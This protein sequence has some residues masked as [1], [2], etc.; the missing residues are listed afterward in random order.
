VA[1]AI[2]NLAYSTVAVAP[3]PALSGLS[4]TVA[5]GQ[6]ALFPTPPF[7]AVVWP[8]GLRPLTTNA[9]LVRVTAIVGDVFTLTRQAES[10]GNRAI[11]VT[12]QIQQALTKQM[13]QDL[14]PLTAGT[15]YPLTGIL[16][17]QASARFKG[18]GPWVDVMSGGLTRKCSASLTTTTGSITGG[19]NTLTLTAAIDFVTGQGVAVIL[20]DS[21]LFTSYITAGGGTTTLT[22]NDNAPSTATTKTVYHDDTLAIQDAIDFASSQGTVYLPGGSYYITNV[23]LRGS[24]ALVG[25]GDG[26]TVLFSLPANTATAMVTLNAV[27]VG[28]AKVQFLRVNGSKTA[29]PAPTCGGVLFDNTGGGTIVNHALLD[30]GVKNTVGDG[31]SL[32]SVVQCKVNNVTIEACNGH[33]YRTDALCFDN[34]VTCLRISTSGLHG[35]FQAGSGDT[36]NGISVGSSGQVDATNFGDNIYITGAVNYFSGFEGHAKRDGIRIDGLNGASQEGKHNN[37]DMFLHSNTNYHVKI[38]NGASQNRIR[39]NM[40]YN[41]TEQALAVLSVDTLCTQNDVELAYYTGSIAASNAPAVGVGLAGNDN[42]L[43][44]RNGSKNGSGDITVF[45]CQPLY[46]TQDWTRTSPT[47]LWRF[48]GSTVYRQ[49]S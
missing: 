41:N 11:L 32:K 15:S 30:M 13:Y 4:L 22:L 42:Y 18:P 9:E 27:T 44:V 2:A 34:T 47:T 21:T 24:V 14:L 49:P 38:T 28:N 35:V 17:V 46:V 7:T 3:A 8:S 23:K 20:D 19:T 26:V 36:F 45:E 10:S 33:G 43:E 12:D 16:D 40:G 31:V 29:S 48:P 1:D 6:G 5:A 25:G 39:G 37:V